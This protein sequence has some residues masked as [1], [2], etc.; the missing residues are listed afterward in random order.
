MSCLNKVKKAVS[1]RKGSRDN[2]PDRAAACLVSACSCVRVVRLSLSLSSRQYELQL[3]AA[4]SRSHLI[5]SRLVPYR[6]GRG[7]RIRS[8]DSTAQHRRAQN[9]RRYLVG[10]ICAARPRARN[11]QS[12]A[13]FRLRSLPFASI[14]SPFHSTPSLRRLA[15]PPRSLLCSLQ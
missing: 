12:S 14:P 15:L 4:R 8:P 10:K 13:R 1:Q 7:G 11:T 5:S 9:T 2:L 6:R 3:V